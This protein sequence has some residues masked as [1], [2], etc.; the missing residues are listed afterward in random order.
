M[1]KRQFVG[2]MI[3]ALAVVVMAG[4]LLASNMGF[5]L[6]YTLNQTLA[7][8]SKSGTNVLALP[9][10]RQ[11]GLNTA[12]NL[13]TD[14]TLANVAQVQKFIK[15]TD[16]FQAYTGRK[17]SGADFA[18]VAGEGLFVK[19]NTA[20]NYI[21]VGSDDPTLAYTLNATQ[22]GVSKSGNNLYAYNYH[23]TAATAKGL[24]DDITLANVAQVQKF[25]KSTDAFQAYTG[26][27]GSAADFN[28][29]P[30]EAYFIK[31]NTTTNYTP[32]HY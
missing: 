26:R 22:A 32:S 11:T 30:G 3:V 31:M 24:L 13:M 4:G 8:T 23:Q 9:D 27:K 15:S 6:N 25:I 2:V 19:M 12:N 18:L 1:N 10:L 7:G 29:T 20:T 14:I 21:V 5:K 17:G 16:A 28:L